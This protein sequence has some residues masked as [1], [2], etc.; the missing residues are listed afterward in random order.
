MEFRINDTTTIP[1]VGFGTYLIDDAQAEIS[2][3]E[4][5]RVGYRH[6]DTAEGYQNEGGVGRALR[7]SGLERDEMF[8]TTKLWPGNPA[9]GHPVKDYATTI[10]ALDSSLERLGLDYVD[11]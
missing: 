3:A 4:A 10:D 8:I 5:L 9:W 2:V 6:I 1:A 11:L 7:Q